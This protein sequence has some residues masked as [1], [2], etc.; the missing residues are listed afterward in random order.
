MKLFYVKI[1]FIW[2]CL[3]YTLNTAWSNKMKIDYEVPKPF[4]L[5]TLSSY[6]LYNYY[7]DAEIFIDGENHIIVLSSFA[8]RN[9]KDWRSKVLL[10]VFDGERWI[11]SENTSLG[12]QYW[13]GMI[14]KGHFQVYTI[15]DLP[16]IYGLTPD[17]KLTVQPIKQVKTNKSKKVFKHEN[18]RQLRELLPVEKQPDNLFIIGH[19]RESR[20]S[21]PANFVRFLAS[22]GHWGFA[23]RLYAATCEQ[24]KVTGYYSIPEKLKVNSLL[25]SR[26]SIVSGNKV[27]VVWV[28][29]TEY[30]DEPKVIQYSHFDLSKKQW[31]EITELFKGHKHSERTF[32]VFSP[33]SLA[34]DNGNVYCVWSWVI[35][36]RTDIGRPIRL[37]ESG[38]YFCSR[39]NGQ[40]NK[41]IKLTDL[42]IQPQVI[43][44]NNGEIYIFWIEQH[45]GLFYK[46]RTDGKWSEAISVVNDERVRVK[47]TGLSG[48]E[49]PPF[50]V[51]VEQ[52]NNMH[53]V[54]IREASGNILGAGTIEAEELVYLRLT[55]EN[56]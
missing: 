19:Y 15:N 21:N 46:H 37:K 8:F 26:D 32:N 47:E 9:N 25:D 38:I 48:A 44:D 29:G 5:H 43:A 31:S 28:K 45:E 50:S 40:W 39:L 42:G 13:G 55:G 22:G 49:S 54:Y 1:I 24:D 20:L 35:T 56:Q 23:T 11:N 30:T 51:A 4:V 14:N 7:D 27:H 36:D 3:L 10:F 33:P 6:G 16:E 18:Y 53:I 34:C 17:M 41:P 52:N 2:C 12:L